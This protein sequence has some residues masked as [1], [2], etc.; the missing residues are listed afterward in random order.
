MNVK[1][2]ENED[3]PLWRRVRDRGV[4]AEERDEVERYI[5]KRQLGICHTG[6]A[7]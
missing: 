6:E 1:E 5:G 4:T 2:R 3:S 7:N